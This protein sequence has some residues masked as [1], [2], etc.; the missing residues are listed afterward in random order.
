[1]ELLVV[2]AIIGI[3]IAL[4]L[5][6]I[7]AAREAARR[8]QCANNLK[9]I[10]LAIAG[11]ENV[12]HHFPPAHVET[13]Y[14]HGMLIYILQYM[15]HP[16]AFKEY[17]FNANWNDAANYVS[18]HNDIP[19]FVCPSARRGGVTSPITGSIRASSPRR[20]LRW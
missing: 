18:I 6:A 4:L 15:E 10:G 14:Q 19:E 3:L 17:N 11:Y 2:I 9:Q 7:Q 12:N 1:M 8:T 20:S 16:A 5:P 13:P